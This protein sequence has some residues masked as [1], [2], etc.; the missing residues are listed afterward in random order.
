MIC[1]EKRK[2]RELRVDALT[3]V[4]RHCAISLYPE[5][6]PDLCSICRGN[7]IL[8]ALRRWGSGNF[9]PSKYRSHL[10][11]GAAEPFPRAGTYIRR[12]Y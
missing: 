10:N 9:K 7:D 1:I 2:T 4:K 12:Q 3:S 5:P 8:N 6:L 11:S